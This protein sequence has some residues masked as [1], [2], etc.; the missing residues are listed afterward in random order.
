[1][2]EIRVCPSC[3]YGRGFHV[4]FKT[5]GTKAQV[6]LICPGCGQSY[7]LGWAVEISDQGLQAAEHYPSHD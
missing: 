5:A 1:M 6:C 2:N 4:S 7:L 3:G